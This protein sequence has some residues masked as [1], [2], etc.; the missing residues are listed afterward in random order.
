MTH[1][2]EHEREYSDICEMKKALCLWSKNQIDMG[3][4]AI[5]TRELGEVIDMIKDLAEAEKSCY[6]ACYYK[7]VVE[8]MDEYGEN[9]RM[10]YNP[11]RNRMGQYSDGR[12]GY[13]EQP[14]ARMM[15]DPDRDGDESYGREFSRYRQAKRYY[16]ETH[17]E[18]E[19]AKMKE[20]ANH[21]ILEAVSTLREIWSEADP[22]LR[23]KMKADLGKLMGEMN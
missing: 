2:K 23:Q 15:R 16:T 6:E 19:R 21:H 9:P 5:D 13:D 11:N 14:Y 10:G 12:S 8:A 4:S 22:D 7:S 18:S 1:M 3:A 17:S 20:H